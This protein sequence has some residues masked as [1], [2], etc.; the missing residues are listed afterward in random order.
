M[1]ISPEKLSHGEREMNKKIIVAGS[2]ILFILGATWGLS[3]EEKMNQQNKIEELMGKLGTRY[4][5]KAADELVEI[6]EEA[7]KPLIE[8]LSIGSGRPSENANYVLGRIGTPEALDAVVKAL[9]NQKFDGRIRGNAAAV[10]GDVGSEKFIDPLIEALEKDGSWWVRHFAVG[11]LGKI[12]TER[13]QEPLIIALKDESQYVRRA[14]VAE[15]GKVKPK[16]A[17]LPLVDC[18]KDDDWQIRL[19]TAEILAGIGGEIEGPLL[20]A[21]TDRNKWVRMGAAAVLGKMKSV[22]AIV[23]LISLFQESD[24]MARSEAALALSRIKSDR[25]VEPLLTLL[26]HR[27]GFVREEAAWV[28]GELR[29]R[30]AVEFL[31]QLLDDEEMGWMAAVSL[32]KIGDK[33]AIAQLEILAEDPESRVGQGALWALERMKPEHSSTIK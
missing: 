10:L 14:A 12:G 8:L 25:A 18:L 6:G 23:P 3:Q 7:V 27:S 4:W 31:I 15:L 1:S 22:E 11:S 2:V 29:S 9:R 21:L 16:I 28:L 17:Y 5:E 20:G 32:G 13:I 30:K 24:W 19:Q 26:K 33:K